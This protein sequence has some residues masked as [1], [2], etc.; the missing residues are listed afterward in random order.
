MML[1]GAAPATNKAGFS[2]L[3][4]EMSAVLKNIRECLAFFS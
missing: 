1:D 4:L 3:A 2:I